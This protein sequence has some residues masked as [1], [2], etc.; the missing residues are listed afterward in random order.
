MPGNLPRRDEDIE[1]RITHPNKENITCKDFVLYTDNGI[2]PVT[3]IGDKSLVIRLEVGQ[4]LKEV[5]YDEACILRSDGSYL[6][7]DQVKGAN[8]LRRDL[9]QTRKL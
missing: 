8:N 4:G 2:Y 7:G 1:E 9:K 3:H 6:I 5:R